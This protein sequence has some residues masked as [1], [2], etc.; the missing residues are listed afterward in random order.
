VEKEE[1]SRPAGK[2]EG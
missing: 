2:H 1:Y